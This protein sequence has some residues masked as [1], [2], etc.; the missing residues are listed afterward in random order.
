VAVDVLVAAGCSATVAVALAAGGGIGEYVGNGDLHAA[1]LP[2]YQYVARAVFDDGR[3]PLWDRHPLCGMPVMAIAQSGAL[4]PPVLVLF[5]LLSP[6]TALQAFY[7]LHAFVLAWGMIAYLRREGIGRAAA[8]I[9][10]LVA[11]AV[12]L[13]APLHNGVDHACLIACAG[14]VPV[15]L[16]A[17]RRALDGDA[18][19]WVA[20]LALAVGLQW[21]AGYPE[22]TLDTAVLLFVVAVVGGGAPLHRRVGL[23][24]A[25]FA[26]GTALAALQM[27]PLQEVV[28]ESPRVDPRFDYAAFRS[29]FSVYSFAVLGHVLTFRFGVGALLLAACGWW[30]AGR[31]GL[32]WL[33]ALVWAVFAVNFPF[34][35]LYELP[36]YA[37]LRFPFGWI[38]VA[39]VFLG[40]SAAA[41]AVALG[42]AGGRA[43]RAAGLCLVVLT[44]GHAL[45]AIWR[46]PTSVPEFQ[47]G[48]LGFRA[49]DR[50][51]VDARVAVLRTL[52]TPDVRVISER[53]VDAG[54][55]IL[56]G[57]AMPNGHEPSVPPRRVVDL[58]HDVG[59]YDALSLYGTQFYRRDWPKL[60][61]RPDLAALLGI[62]YAVISEPEAGVLTAVGFRRAASL[63]PGDAVL[64][65]PPIPR[66]RVV[67][68]TVE[69]RGEA[70]TH[71]LVLAHAADAATVS[72]VEAGVMPG[73]L[74]EPP[75]GATETVRIVEDRPERVEIEAH[76]AAPALV[77]LTDTWYPGWQATVDGQPA[78]IVRADH[79]FRGVRVTAGTHRIVYRYLPWR[80]LAGG[81]CSAAAALAIAACLLR[82]R[83][84]ARDA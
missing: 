45:N 24:V 22:V 13:R 76:V 4:Y 10:A 31:V 48:A 79:A 53:E 84:S 56:D 6:W 26:L 63:P 39:G 51:L 41:G 5:R 9:A 44:V 36:P 16:A 65:R 57:L 30:W 77:V 61:A 60:A 58:L 29:V 43:A 62:G 46:A 73:A 21:V 3:L 78:P 35:L 8:A 34:R 64:Y 25:G 23:L 15:M 75:V 7:A 19:H 67:H 82:R 32:A 12:V 59:L 55:A 72:V 49:P 11:V 14:W 81:A 2:W 42:R 74:A 28:A 69:G 71:A 83:P 54:A 20:V 70:E 66:L 50:P 37:G 1:H 80:V 47:P 68:R 27:L 40:V 38:P 33:A 18:A 52:L 17:W